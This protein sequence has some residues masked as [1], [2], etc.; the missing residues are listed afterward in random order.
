MLN[1]TH[2]IVSIEGFT[3]SS[4]VQ[5]RAFERGFFRCIGTGPGEPIKG[6]MDVLF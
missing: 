3:E 4:V 5:S 2:N 1:K 6:L